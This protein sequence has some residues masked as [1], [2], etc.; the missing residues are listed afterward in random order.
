MVGYGRGSKNGSGGCCNRYFV[1]RFFLAGS[2]W[3]GSKILEWNK[4]YAVNFTVHPFTIHQIS[5]GFV[6]LLLTV[7]VISWHFESGFN[8]PF[9][10]QPLVGRQIINM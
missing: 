10:D 7:T 5:L 2:S 1:F 9:D 3:D 6:L 8:A 4:I